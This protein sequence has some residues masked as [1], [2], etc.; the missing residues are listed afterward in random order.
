M[1]S[2]TEQ[3][4]SPPQPEEGAPGPAL[5][6]GR[7]NWLATAALG[8]GILG[9]LLITIPAG[10][11][12]GVLGLRRASQAREAGRPGAGRV[13]C[14]LAIALSLAWAGAVGYLLPHLIRA[15]DPGCEAYKDNVLTSYNRVVADVNNGADRAVLARDLTTAVRQT[16]PGR[17]GQPEP[18]RRAVADRAVQRVADHARRRPGRA[19]SAAPGP[20]HPEQG[21]RHRRRRLRHRLTGYFC[22]ASHTSTGPGGPAPH[23]QSRCPGQPKPTIVIMTLVSSGR[24]A[25]D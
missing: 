24:N 6:A 25:A 13:R 9:G 23:P 19:D 1:S 20:A 8:C 2:S 3:A 12:L 7:R 17:A 11:V 5:A 14:W 22:P 10:L 18:G 4:A 21:H 16:S 15:A